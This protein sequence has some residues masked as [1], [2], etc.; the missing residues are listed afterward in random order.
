[1]VIKHLSLLHWRL[2]E[3]QRLEKVG[4]VR[5]LKKLSVQNKSW[6]PRF[7][8]H[9]KEKSIKVCFFLNETQQLNNWEYRRELVSAKRG[10]H[11]Q[12][13]KRVMGLNGLE[14]TNCFSYR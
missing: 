11:K 2:N 5:L 13:H 4:N 1:M 9:T 10:K 7:K 8:T 14:V 6:N 3:K 12:I